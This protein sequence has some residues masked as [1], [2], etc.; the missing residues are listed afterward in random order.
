[1][2][3]RLMIAIAG[4][5]LV[6]AQLACSTPGDR[7]LDAWETCVSQYGV[8]ACQARMNTHPSKRH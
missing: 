8:E 7:F 5:M 6:L 4:L 2:K 1:M 3:R